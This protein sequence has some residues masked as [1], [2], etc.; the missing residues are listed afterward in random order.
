MKKILYAVKRNSRYVVYFLLVIVCGVSFIFFEILKKI[1]Y[2]AQ[3]EIISLRREINELKDF[4]VYIKQLDNF[5]KEKQLREIKKTQAKEIV[6]STVD[7]FVRRFDAKVINGLTQENNLF[8]AK[9]K[10]EHKLSP[11]I[12]DLLDEM[13]NSFMPIYSF[14]EFK[15]ENNKVHLRFSIVQPFIEEQH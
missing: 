13:L 9:L 6:L 12:K 14:E 11:Q 1:D 2:K 4:E 7:F 10:L 15:L 3:R 5:I 8:S